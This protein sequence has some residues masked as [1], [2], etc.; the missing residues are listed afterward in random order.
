[1]EFLRP[2]QSVLAFLTI[3][4]AGKDHD[5]RIAGGMIGLAMTMVIELSGVRGAAIAQ[6]FAQFRDERRL[7]AFR[8]YRGHLRDCIVEG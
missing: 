5:I 7:G 4:P 2:V 6:D 1:M 3:L 8:E